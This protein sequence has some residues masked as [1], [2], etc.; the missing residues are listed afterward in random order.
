MRQSLPRKRSTKKGNG[1]QGGEGSEINEKRE[2]K[3]AEK[4][5]C[6]RKEMGR[7]QPICSRNANQ[8]RA[9]FRKS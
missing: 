6:A 5:D 9:S 3:G 7:A 1:P 8:G 4:E 2:R